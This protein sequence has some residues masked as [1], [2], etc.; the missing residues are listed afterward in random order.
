MP[1]QPQDPVAVPH[2]RC[3]SANEVQKCLTGCFSVRCQVI[4]YLVLVRTATHQ[5][6]IAIMGDLDARHSAHGY[7][8]AIVDI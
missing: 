7:L 3:T 6:R 8:D 2:Q 4:D 1:T 5:G